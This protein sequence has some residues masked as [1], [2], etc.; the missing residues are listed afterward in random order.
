MIRDCRWQRLDCWLVLHS[1]YFW[2]RQTL[3]FER[4]EILFAIESFDLLG[5]KMDRFGI[6]WK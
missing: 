3:V 2:S 1:G 4:S 5:I 6:G